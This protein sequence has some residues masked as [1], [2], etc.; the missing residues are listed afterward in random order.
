MSL[1]RTAD[2][3]SGI[4]YAI[5]AI[6]GVF[7]IIGTI[8]YLTGS[9]P[10]TAQKT[11]E[12]S[13]VQLMNIGRDSLDLTLITPAYEI[14]TGGGTP[15]AIYKLEADKY[16][17]I[18]PGDTVNFSVYYANTNLPI[19]KPLIFD[20]TMLGTNDINN[21]NITP[22]ISTAT[23]YQDN[24][25]SWQKVPSPSGNPPI[26]II[27]QADPSSERN[28]TYEIIAHDSFGYSNYVTIKIGYYN[29]TLNTHSTYKG[30]TVSG[31]VTD[32]NG[33]GV[34]GLTI[35]IWK[36][37]GNNL[38]IDDSVANTI[39]G[40]IFSFQWSICCSVGT[41]YIQAISTTGKESNM[42]II[43]DAGGSNAHDPPPPSMLCA[44]YGGDSS[45][46][47]ITVYEGNLV[48]LN[49]SDITEFGQGNFFVNYIKDYDSAGAK[50]CESPSFSC[51]IKT[52]NCDSNKCYNA[53]FTAPV[54]GI[55]S[56]AICSSPTCN[57]WSAS[58]L[59]TNLLFIYVL[60]VSAELIEDT[61]VNATELNMYMRLYLPP[62][63]NYNLYLIAPNGSRFTECPGFE[64]GQLINGYPTAEAVTVSKLFHIKYPPPPYTPIIDNIT[65]F[66][67]VLW[68]K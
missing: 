59:K 21:F 36:Y 41:Y 47:S 8:I 67:M 53:T 37:N 10:Y 30:R 38:N 58:D 20:G 5:E 42:E 34:D 57:P 22:N 55:Y 31:V 18:I 26:G 56:I 4:T 46:E 52:T 43:E 35:R 12:H 64:T 45:C 2:N 16:A 1:K 49:K 60:P 3:E 23:V 32:A 25:Q 14:K 51:Y 33:S 62:N 24:N 65:E 6:I 39:A 44:S 7:L 63:V 9:M 19:Y 40:G 61:C 48:S 13:K 50:G 54:P 68:Y 11:G 27:K 66:R 29:L 15:V 28:F 17:N